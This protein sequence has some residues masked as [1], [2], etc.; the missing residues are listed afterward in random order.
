[1]VQAATVIL[2]DCGSGMRIT[3]WMRKQQGNELAFLQHL[4]LFIAPMQTGFNN[5]I[6]KKWLMVVE[7]TK[8]LAIPY[9]NPTRITANGA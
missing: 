8:P 5:L 3:A 9:V 6:R 1:M 7:L 2:S 4:I